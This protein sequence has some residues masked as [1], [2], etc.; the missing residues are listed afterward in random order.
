MPVLFLGHGSPMNAIEG[1]R[2]S[3]KLASARPTIRHR[4][5]AT[6]TDFVH[7]CTLADSRRVAHC[8]GKTANHLRLWRLSASSVRPAISC[9]RRTFCTREIA[10]QFS[11][12]SL[13]LDKHQWGLDHSAWAVLKPMFP[14]ASILTVQLSMDYDRPRNCEFRAGPATLYV[15][16]S[17]RTHRRQRQ[18]RS[19]PVRHETRRGAQWGVRLGHRIRPHYWRSNADWQSRSVAGFSKNGAGGA[20]RTSYV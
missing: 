7:L 9:A 19:Q 18:Y 12:L 6:A 2:L 10:A 4:V 13:D 14:D 11:H 1:Q 15:A 5:C 16:R 17:R 8:N 20:T 3:Q